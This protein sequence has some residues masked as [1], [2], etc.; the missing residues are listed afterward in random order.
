MQAV[1]KTISLRPVHLGGT[2]SNP[3]KLQ[4]HLVG[5]MVRAPTELTPVVRQDGIDPH[6]ERRLRFVER[7]GRGH[8]QL[9]GVEASL[10][11]A[12][13]ALQHGLQIHIA[14]LLERTDENGVDGHQYSGVVNLYLT[15]V[16]LGIEALEQANLLIIELNRL[17]LVG[18]LAHNKRSSL[19]SK[20]WLPHTTHT[21]RSDSDTLQC[22][23]LRYPL[24]AVSRHGE[25]VIEDDL[26]N[27]GCAPLKPS[28]LSNSPSAS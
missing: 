14:N 6:K 9:A 18:F 15:F 26:F 7:M 13:V 16:K 5:M 17:F 4:E 25:V 22:K 23:L 24:R 2:V 19:E 20:S 12:T 11:V 10:G 28:S 21:A 8:R 3:L 27:L 1:D